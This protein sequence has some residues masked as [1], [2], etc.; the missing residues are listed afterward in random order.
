M[1]EDQQPL[2]FAGASLLLVAPLAIMSG[3]P[4]FV[5]LVAVVLLL[6]ALASLVLATTHLERDMV[7][8]G[9][10]GGAVGMA[11]APA[12][13]AGLSVACGLLVGALVGD[14]IRD[15]RN[16]QLIHPDQQR[17]RRWWYRS[18]GDPGWTNWVCWLGA[19]AGACANVVL[20]LTAVAR[21]PE[22]QRIRWLDELYADMIGVEQYVP[23]LLD[24]TITS[25]QHVWYVYVL[26]AV[27][28]ASV[29]RLYQ[30][31]AEPLEVERQ[32]RRVAVAH[33][34]ALLLLAGTAIWNLT[35]TFNEA[36]VTPAAE[37][38]VYQQQ[39]AALMSMLRDTQPALIL[40]MFTMLLLGQHLRRYL[41]RH[42]A[43]LALGIV[44]STATLLVFIQSLYITKTWLLPATS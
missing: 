9:V 17:L 2:L 14:T 37:S 16:S 35:G 19:L 34:L 30:R 33:G 13:A 18:P 38:E 20:V 41:L 44:G 25:L 6:A 3:G 15:G 32:L 23:S 7:H 22:D 31:P 4:F 43:P 24:M 40:M 42:G 12:G 8:M 27:A 36:R 26:L 11:L 39:C 21:I 1:S 10:L 5:Q 28:L 29:W